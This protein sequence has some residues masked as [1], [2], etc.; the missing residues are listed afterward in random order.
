VAITDVFA[1]SGLKVPTLTEASYVELASFFRVVGASYRNPI[2]IGTANRDEIGRIIGIVERDANVD[3]LIFIITMHL[4]TP[5]QLQG[6]VDLMI[7]TRKRTT[8][9]VMGIVFYSNGTEMDNAREVMLKLQE[10]GI[11]A[12]PAMERGARALRNDL[13][14]YR[15]KRSSDNN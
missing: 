9:P 10:A 13:Q 6:N 12:F 2:D 11:A 14:Y 4:R 8:K 5:A 1:E 3:N 15:F 7:N